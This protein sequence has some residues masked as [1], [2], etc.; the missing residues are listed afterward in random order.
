MTDPDSLA[1]RVRDGE[2]RIHELEEHA[3]HDVAAA[4]RRR[5][6][7]RET[8]ADLETV[9]EYG[10]PAERAEPNVENMIRAAQVPMGVAGPVPVHGGAA[11]GEHYLPLATTEER[12]SP[13]SIAASR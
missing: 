10:F 8:G 12:C 11:D 4:A 9:G 2:L 6:V 7:E 13:R 1:D 3:D 5:L